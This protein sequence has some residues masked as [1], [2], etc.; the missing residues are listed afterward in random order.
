MWCSLRCQHCVASLGCECDARLPRG[1]DEREGAANCCGSTRGA[2]VLGA[3]TGRTMSRYFS[4]TARP[5]RVA[6]YA[7]ISTSIGAITNRS[8]TSLIAAR[9]RP[10]SYTHLRAHETDSYLVCRLLLEKK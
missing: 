9:R 7:S 5:S 10:V 4:A 1:G 3:E 8:V 6:R 2:Q